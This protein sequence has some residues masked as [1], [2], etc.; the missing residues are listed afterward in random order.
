M[1]FHQEILILFFLSKLNHLFISLPTP[2]HEIIASLCEDVF[3]FI[4]KAKCDKVKRVVVT[5][6]YYCGVLKMVNI[7]NFIKS[8][9]CS[10]IKKFTASNQPWKDIFLAI[11][12]HDVVKKC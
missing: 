9:K 11:H 2:K 12:G 10:W 3:E 6:D 7:D 4:W 8:L 5:K 1:Y